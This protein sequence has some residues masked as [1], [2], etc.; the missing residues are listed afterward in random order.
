M[1]LQQIAE[2]YGLG[3]GYSSK[4]GTTNFQVLPIKSASI[5]KDILNAYNFEQN[6]DFFESGSSPSKRRTKNIYLVQRVKAEQLPKDSE[7]EIVT[8]NSYEPAELKI[9]ASSIKEIFLLC[10]IKSNFVIDFYLIHDCLDSFH[11]SHT[12]QI[13]NV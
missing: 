11:Y 10:N 8:L 3:I 1:E 12:C 9:P 4:S 13:T 7:I 6:I 2:N 5:A